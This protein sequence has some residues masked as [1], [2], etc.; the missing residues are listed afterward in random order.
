M[1]RGRGRQRSTGN[2]DR[3]TEKGGQRAVER[4]TTGRTK[5]RKGSASPDTTLSQVP[6]SNA[7]FLEANFI[8]E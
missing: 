8:K 4:E 7:C 5:G 1:E 6:T 3:N 2:R